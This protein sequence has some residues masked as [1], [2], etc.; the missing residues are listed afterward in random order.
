MELFSSSD[1][2]SLQLCPQDL[3][4]SVGPT[5]YM[6]CRVGSLNTFD[7]NRLYSLES[8]VLCE[9]RDVLGIGGIRVDYGAV[10]KVE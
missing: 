10:T 6:W 4:V 8:V 2:A 5:Q 1:D 9:A 3:C 7:C